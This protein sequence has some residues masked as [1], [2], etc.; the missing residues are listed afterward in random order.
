MK[1]L[2]AFVVGIAL[3]AQSLPAG[4]QP[5][6]Q[7]KTV[8]IVHSSGPGDSYDTLSRL[9]ARHMGRHLPGNPTVI[10]RS[11]RGGGGIIAANHLYNVA[12]KDGTA[13]GMLE[14]SIFEVQLFTPASLKA[15]VRKLNWVGRVIS[16]NAGLYAWHTAA[17]KK[18]E[19]AY[20]KEL[21]VSSTARASQTRWTVLKNLL[22]VKFRLIT[23]HKGSS[24]GMLAMERGEVDAVS[25][26]WTVFR[27][28]RAQW[29]HEKKV[30]V[31]L[32]TGT[33]AAPDLPGVPRVIDLARNEEERT[34]LE[35]FSQAEKVGRSFSAPPGMPPE[36]V[37]DLRAAYVATLEDPAFLA[38]ADAMGVALD[39]MS[40]DAMQAAIAKFFDHP[41]ALIAKAIA[42]TKME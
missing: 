13:L 38:D 4:A 30:N 34:I 11:M 31:L 29:L 32:Q 27:V 23:G 41:P 19:D 42:L 10:V 22:G 6:Y 15:D 33:E 24:E 9:F 37:A 35:L 8:E 7:G 26:P 3:S 2:L 28:T 5:Y 25:I 21:I 18:I 1:A 17:V 16:N 40:G 36:R 12:P 20:T 39:P 14:Q